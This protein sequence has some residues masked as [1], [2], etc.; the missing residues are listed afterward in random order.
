MRYL[1]AI[2]AA[3]IAASKH[4]AGVDAATTGTGDSV[5]P[6][7]DQQQIGL[8]RFRRHARRRAGALDVHD[9]ERELERDRQPHRLGRGRCPGR[10]T[11]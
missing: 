8:L 7:H 3:S 10:P 5:P 4:P 11:S 2:R 6:E 9:D 1:I